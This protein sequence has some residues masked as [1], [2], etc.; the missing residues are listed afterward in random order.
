MYLWEQHL[1]LPARP[2]ELSSP[3]SIPGVA[4]GTDR[5]I[6]VGSGG[7]DSDFIVPRR[8]AGPAELPEAQPGS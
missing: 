6:S 3:R 7:R 5:D 8:S 1:L 4:M 2:A